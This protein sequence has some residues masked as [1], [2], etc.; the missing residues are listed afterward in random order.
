[1]T[2]SSNSFISVGRHTRSLLD[3]TMRTLYLGKPVLTGRHL[4]ALLRRWLLTVSFSVVIN[5]WSAARLLNWLARVIFAIAATNM[6]Q[7]IGVC[8][9][10]HRIWET[11]SVARL[12]HRGPGTA[13]WHS[14]NAADAH[15][16]ASNWSLLDA[17]GLRS[18]HINAIVVV[19][20]CTGYANRRAA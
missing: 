3:L 5:I 10:M 17:S 16:D 20:I 18:D 6:W 13:A 12:I 7:L 14:T 8:L 1:M 11:L 4:L 15:W 9:S 2:A 19:S